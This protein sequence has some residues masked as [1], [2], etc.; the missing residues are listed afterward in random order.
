LR[1]FFFSGI[2]YWF[3]FLLLALAA[4]IWVYYDSARRDLDA[5]SWR[6]GV[7]VAVGLL[8]P[9]IFFKFSVQESQ[10]YE[11]Y[12][13]QSQIQYLETYQEPEDWRFTVDELR[14]ELST[15]PPLTGALEPIMYMGLLGGLGGPILAIAYTITY[16][17]QTGSRQDDP[18]VAPPPPPP[19]GGY[20]S[21]QRRQPPE[22][23][24]RPAAPPPEVKPKAHAW[25]VSQDGRSYQL[26]QGETTI[27]RSAQ[28]DIQIGN[29]AT[30]SKSHAKIVEQNNHFRFFD[31]GS[32]N[33]SRVNDRRVREPVLL[34]AN[35]RIQL[36]DNTHLNF[37]T[38]QR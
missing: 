2:G 1:N 23:R 4:L 19:G 28:N 11:Y 17:G 36:G 8:L 20:S 37:V 9:S 15:Y 16:Q 21:S 30:V 18:V 33:G 7:L 26:N 29:D 12:D 25:L 6:I 3:Y 31:L 38:S 34:A 14:A 13:I 32:T 5:I 24:K 35:D 27:G 22:P 10:V